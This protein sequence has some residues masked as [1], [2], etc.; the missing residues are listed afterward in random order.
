MFGLFC[1]SLVQGPLGPQSNNTIFHCCL[2]LLARIRV[3]RPSRVVGS[4]SWLLTEG[5][6]TPTS[7]SM[8]S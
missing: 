2:G 3:V 8:K 7:G 5:V 1:F 4:H 6:I